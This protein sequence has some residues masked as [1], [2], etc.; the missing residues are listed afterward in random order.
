MMKKK[1]YFSLRHSSIS[2]SAYQLSFVFASMKTYKAM[3][4]HRSNYLSFF[5][6]LRPG[7]YKTTEYFSIDLLFKNVS[8]NQKTNTSSSDLKKKMPY[9]VRK[10]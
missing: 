2:Y 1:L 6:R 7:E 3:S 9:E 8:T 4:A 10:V 5:R